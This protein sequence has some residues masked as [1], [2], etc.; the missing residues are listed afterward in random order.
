MIDILLYVVIVVASAVVA[1]WFSFIFSRTFFLPFNRQHQSYD[2]R[3]EVRKENNQNC[4]VRQLCTVICTREQFL[5]LRVGLGLY[6]VFVCLF[7]FSI[8]SVYLC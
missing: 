2:D 4:S 7:R 6:F 5:N 3:L 8:F 1:E